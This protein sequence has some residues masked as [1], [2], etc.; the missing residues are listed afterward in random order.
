MKNAIFTDENI[1]LNNM[2][3]FGL[4]LVRILAPSNMVYPFLQ[5]RDTTG[6]VST[7][8]CR[9]CSEKEQTELC[10]HSER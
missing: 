4:V 1:K 9:F 8:V 2:S 5:L 10:Q 3:I 6:K 7:P